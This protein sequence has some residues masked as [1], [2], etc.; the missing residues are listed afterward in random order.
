MTADHLRQSRQERIR[1]WPVTSSAA[2]LWGIALLI[3][4][5]A[6]TFV[7]FRII[8]TGEPARLRAGRDAAEGDVQE[9]EKVLGLN[10]SLP[11]QFWNT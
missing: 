6:L 11:A 2:I 5:C 1:R 9:I 10:K 7:F 8:P 4:V 3:I